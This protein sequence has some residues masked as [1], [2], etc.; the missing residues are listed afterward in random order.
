MKDALESQRQRVYQIPNKPKE[1]I[2]G[3]KN[4]FDLN[5]SS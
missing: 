1:E 4:R 3:A 2:K 5:L